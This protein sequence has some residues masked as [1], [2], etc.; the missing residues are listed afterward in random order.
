MPRLSFTKSLD[1]RG[2]YDVFVAGA[3]P[4]GMAAAVSAARRG[5][6]VFLAERIG[7]LGGLGTAGLVPCFCSF[8]TGAKLLVRGIGTEVVDR[9]RAAGGTGPEDRPGTYGH[10]TIRPEILKVVYDDMA[11][12][13]GITVRLSTEVVDVI[14]SGD[15]V[16]AAVLCGR[17]GLYAVEADVFVD[18][19]GDAM[20]C[21]VAGA[22]WGMGDDAGNVQ[23]ITLAATYVNFDWQRLRQ[24]VGEHGDWRPDAI[25]RGIAEGVLSVP[26]L[27]HSGVSHTSPNTCG[28]N[29]SHVY[30]RNPIDDEQLTLAYMEGRK[31]ALEYEGFYRRYAP[32]FENV[33]IVA[34]A[35]LM[36]VRESRRVLGEYTLNA[37]DFVRRAVFE[38]EI[39][40]YANPIDVHPSSPDPEDF[41]RF[42]REFMEMYRYQRGD[43]YGIPYRSLIPKDLSNVLVAGRC[44]STDRQMQGSVRVM[45]SCFLTGQAAGAAA[46]LCV[47]GNRRPRDI[48]AQRLR[49]EL[50]R[51]GAYLP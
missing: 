7:C 44:I 32:G 17:G 42:R 49:A 24:Y 33:E 22:R 25:Q 41:A 15:T 4:A 10:V 31:L 38:D 39:G 23:G 8:G 6:R 36:G 27:H 29:V 46:A 37:D 51:G 28:A 50:R 45:P 20:L 5:R 40:R 12:E 1:V 47:E 35:S 18:A 21:H 16:Q 11:I 19:T 34:V 3:G 2:H 26:D 43:S 9:L 14:K 30:G 48:D 13:A